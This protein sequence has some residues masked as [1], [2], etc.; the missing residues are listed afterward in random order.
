MRGA[1]VFAVWLAGFVLLN[2]GAVHAGWEN[3]SADEVTLLALK[4]D[5]DNGFRLYEKYC[6][7][8]HELEGWGSPDGEFPVVAGQHR[9]VILKQL[10]DMRNGKRKKSEMEEVL[11]EKALQSPQALAD[12]VAYVQT[13]PMS[14]DNGLGRGLDTERGGKIYEKHCAD[15]HGKYAE[16]NSKKSYPLLRSQHYRYML[17]QFKAVRSGE[18]GNG[19]P[20][21]EKIAKGMSDED[22]FAVL[23]YVSRLKP[24]QAQRSASHYLLETLG[25]INNR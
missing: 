10:L 16:G 4:P 19:H 6:F 25:N 24:P 7:E 18:R 5:V 8:C 23:D 12:M 22:V 17:R 3:S 2:V 13:L 11:D 15:C 14:P 20:K 1:G 21:M 9:S